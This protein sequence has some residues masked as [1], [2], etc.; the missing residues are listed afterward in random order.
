MFW[1]AHLSDQ[2]LLSPAQRRNRLIRAEAERLTRTAPTDPVIVAGVTGS[3]PATVDLMR[4]VAALPAG[5]IV[6][7]GLDRALDDASWREVGTHPEHPQ[8]GLAK[9]LAALG[10]ARAAVGEVAGAP[11]AAGAAARTVF[12]SEAMRPAGATGDVGGLHRQ[13]RSRRH[14]RRPSPA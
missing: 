7:P 1:P 4:A 13:R 9:L 8:H 6:I 14:P 5:A 2:N 11:P 3:V 10:V 12:L